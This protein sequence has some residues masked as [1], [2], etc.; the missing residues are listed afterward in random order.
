MV[1]DQNIAWSETK[2]GVM[3]YLGGLVAC[4]SEHH[5]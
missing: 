1:F 4:F 2:I 3:V 5:L